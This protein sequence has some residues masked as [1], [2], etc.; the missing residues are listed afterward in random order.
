MNK[1][2][3]PKDATNYLVLGA[4]KVSQAEVT[5]FIN[6]MKNKKDKRIACPICGKLCAL[7]HPCIHR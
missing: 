1:L 6:S 7:G 2:Y 5:R 3:I 4:D